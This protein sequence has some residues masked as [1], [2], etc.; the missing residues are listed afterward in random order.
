MRYA[1]LGDIHSAEEDLLAVLAHI[2]ETAPDAELIGTGDLFE[3]TVSK[4]DLR[5]QVYEQAA[6]VAELPGGLLAL[7]DFPS[8]YGNQ[9]ERILLLTERDE[10]LRGKISALPETLQLEGALIIHGHQWPHGEGRPW[11]EEQLKDAPLVIHGHTHRSSLMLAGQPAA[12]RFGEEIA[13]AGGQCIANAGAV[14]ESREWLLYDSGSRTI[15]FMKAG[16]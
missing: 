15:R 11:I 8:V 9:E 5:G 2:R 4:K 14:V 10:P 12:V 3:C 7:L 13:L 16:N 1:V 6:D